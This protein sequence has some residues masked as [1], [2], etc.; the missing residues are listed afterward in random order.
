[1]RPARRRVEVNNA[2]LDFETDPLDTRNTGGFNVRRSVIISDTNTRSR[3]IV[4]ASLAGRPGVNGMLVL[5]ESIFGSLGRSQLIK[6]VPPFAPCDS[7]YADDQNG[8][9][10]DAFRTHDL[11]PT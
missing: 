9:M 4:K 1:M 5:A 3:R 6:F 7:C 8:C 10:L 2:V 11:I